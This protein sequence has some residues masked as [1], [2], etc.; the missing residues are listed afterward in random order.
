[1]ASKTYAGKSTRKPTR[2]IPY[3]SKIGKGDGEQRETSVPDFKVMA[4]YTFKTEKEA[5]EVER[6]AQ[7][8][9]IIKTQ[10]RKALREYSDGYTEFF[11]ITYRQA[12]G[13]ILAARNMLVKLG[14]N[15]L[16]A[17][18]RKLARANNINMTYRMIMD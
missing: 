11:A 3:S 16:R 13:F 17:A 9:A 12:M 8:L 10:K 1:M 15:G 14:V 5:N 6:Y 2:L 4:S 7:V 18:R